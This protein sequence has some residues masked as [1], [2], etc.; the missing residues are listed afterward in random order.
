MVE[1]PFCTPG[2]STAIGNVRVPEKPNSSSEKGLRDTFV[3]FSN[4]G[5]FVSYMYIL[6]PKISILV[7]ICNL[8]AD[9]LR[10]FSSSSSFPV[11][12]LFKKNTF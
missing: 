11:S 9:T 7:A 1:P 6:N 5:Y 2:A 8:P 4:V 12:L 10:F 3:T